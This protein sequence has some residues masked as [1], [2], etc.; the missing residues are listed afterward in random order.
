[1]NS[2]PHPTLY[3]RPLAKHYKLG[4]PGASNLGGE[5]EKNPNRDRESRA[6]SLSVSF[7]LSSLISF[8]VKYENVK[9]LARTNTNMPHHYQHTGTDLVCIPG[10]H[11]P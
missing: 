2:L 10:A 6:P 7:Y 4:S 3:E 5:P 8:I 1:M 11:T 9:K